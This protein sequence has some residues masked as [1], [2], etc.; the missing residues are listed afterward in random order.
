MIMLNKNFSLSLSLSLISQLKCG[1]ATGS[2][3]LC[4]EYFKFSNYKLNV[5]LSMRFTLFFTHSY[6]PSS[7]IETIIVPIVNNNKC[8]NLSDS[9]NYKPIALATVMAKLFESVML[10]KCEMFLDTCPNQF[11][12]KKVAQYRHVHLCTG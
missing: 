10:L 6:L 8:G 5:L 12:F 11:G 2:E 4:A 7:M 1:K 3:N 9:N